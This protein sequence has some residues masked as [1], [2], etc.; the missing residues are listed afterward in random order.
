MGGKCGIR[1][2]LLASAP[3]FI[4]VKLYA[5][6]SSAPKVEQAPSTP[7]TSPP[8]NASCASRGGTNKV[9]LYPLEVDGADSTVSALSLST[10]EGRITEHKSRIGLIEACEIVEISCCRSASDLIAVHATLTLAELVASSSVIAFVQ[11]Y[12][13]QSLTRFLYRQLDARL[14]KGDIRCV[15]K[16]TVLP[17][18]IT[19]APSPKLSINLFRRSSYSLAGIPVVRCFELTRCG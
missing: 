9:Y 3:H 2:R 17:I 19:T 10:R 4:T 7:L 6:T 18:Q 15:T 11:C 12:K 5:S 1:E 16:R 14:S 13:S 8:H